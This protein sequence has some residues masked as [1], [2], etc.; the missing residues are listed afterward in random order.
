MNRT[1]PSVDQKR[2]DDGQ[3]DRL[4]NGE[5]T[6]RLKLIESD[7]EDDDQAQNSETIRL[8]ESKINL[9]ESKANKVCSNC[10]KTFSISN[11]N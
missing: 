5:S 2:S 10:S 4:T 3:K 11:Q 8:L 6:K 7:E 9:N 1:E